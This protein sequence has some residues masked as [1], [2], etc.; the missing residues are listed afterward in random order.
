M[1]L[2]HD[3]PEN[4]GVENGIKRARQMTSFRWTPAAALPACNLGKDMDLNQF[5]LPYRLDPSFPQQGLIYSS[6]LL[7]QKFIG[8]NVSFES[9]VS[10]L[11]DP[12]SVLYKYNVN[13]KG[14]KNANC[15]YGV[16]CSCFASYVL[17]MKERWICKQWPAVKNVT[18]LGQPELN[19]LKLL[20]IVLNTKRHIAIITDI[21]RDENGD[22]QRIEISESTLPF[23]RATYFTPEE[24]RRHWYGREFGIYR[25]SDNESIS[26]TPSPFVRIEADPKRG[27]E[28]DP[29]LPEI[30]INKDILPDQGNRTNYKKNQEIVLDLLTEGWDWVE[31]SG[32]NGERE[33]FDIRDGIAVI[34]EKSSSHR[35]GFYTAKAVRKDSPA[36]SAPVA[37]AVTGLTITMEKEICNSENPESPAR[38]P[39]GSVQTV[40]FAND[41]PDEPG[42]LYIHALANAGERMRFALTEKDR[43]NGCISVRLPEKEDTYF[44]FLS[45]E[46]KYGEYASNYLYF[47]AEA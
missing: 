32:E 44:M 47:T 18:Y 40:R 33:T 12:K 5:Y 22:V 16:V 6:V 26:Y 42:M 41:M 35:A 24:F 1:K 37:Y 25:K 30:R 28:G 3:I 46:N 45:S 43:R 23:C 9:F 38:I 36:E 11:S 4:K 17:G 15:W 14:R 8:F 13:G 34:P 29:E 21:L 27:L 7:H 20:D 19:E 10:A 2:N 31:V 39:A